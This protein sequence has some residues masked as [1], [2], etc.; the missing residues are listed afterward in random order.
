M[1]KLAVSPGEFTY[2]NLDAVAVYGALCWSQGLT[3]YTDIFTTVSHIVTIKVW[4]EREMG[5]LKSSIVQ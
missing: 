2:D 5:Q 3:L 1:A 4:L